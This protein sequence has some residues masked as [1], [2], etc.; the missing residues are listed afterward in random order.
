MAKARKDLA[1]VNAVKGLQG[2]KK[3]DFQK[4]KLT[5]PGIHPIYNLPN[6]NMIRPLLTSLDYPK[7]FRTYTKI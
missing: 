5:P 7:S 2:L 3:K 6:F 4:L 1:L